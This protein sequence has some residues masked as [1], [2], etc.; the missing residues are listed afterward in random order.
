MHYDDN[1]LY[2]S[3]MP[4]K[5]AK[6]LRKNLTEAEKQ[7]WRALRQRQLDGHYFRRQA[8]IGA[9]VADF[10]C[11]KKRLIIEI[12]GGQHALKKQQDDKRTNWLQNEGFSVIRFW[13]N[14]VLENLEGVLESIRAVLNESPPPKPSPIKGEGL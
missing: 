2:A 9:Y 5:N 13:N 7:L 4:V 12:D 10:V 8:S 11:F 1:W 14:E 6:Y 3:D